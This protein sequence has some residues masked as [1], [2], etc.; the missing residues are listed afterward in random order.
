MGSIESAVVRGKKAGPEMALPFFWCARQDSRLGGLC[1][2][3]PQQGERLAKT[4]LVLASCTKSVE[5]LRA[6]LSGKVPG[7]YSGESADTPWAI[8]TGGV[9]EYNLNTISNLNWPS[10]GNRLISS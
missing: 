6:G 9:S 2:L 4:P 3:Q 10:R 7:H 1:P 8:T 5:E